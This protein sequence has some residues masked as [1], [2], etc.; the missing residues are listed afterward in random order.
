M[1]ISDTIQNTGAWHF[2]YI[3]IL[4][5]KSILD[6]KEWQLIKGISKHKYYMNIQQGLWI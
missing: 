3:K 2:S 4:D 5:F 6:C 1:I